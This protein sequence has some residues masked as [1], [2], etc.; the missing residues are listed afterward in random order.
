VASRGSQSVGAPRKGPE[1]LDLRGAATGVGSLPFRS[2]ERAVRWSLTRYRDVPFWPQ[3]PRRSSAES[4]LRQFHEPLAGANAA[5][6]GPFLRAMRGRFALAVKGQV[7]GPVTLWLA[8]GGTTTLAAARRESERAAR[9]VTRALAALGP[10]PIVFVDEPALHELRTR[11]AR[12]VARADAAI[13]AVI[14]TIRRRGARAGIHTCGPPPI[15]RLLRARPDFLGLDFVRYRDRLLAAVAR[16]DVRAFVQRGGAF[17]FGIVPTAVP[18]GFAADRVARFLVHDLLAAFG[19]RRIVI[20]LL[21]RSLVTA[22]CGTG[23]RSVDD[24]R[25]VARALRSIH[26]SLRRWLRRQET[27]ARGQ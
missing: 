25:A 12:D 6:F 1:F 20:D 27:P 3:L 11:P 16:R 9:D 17:A 18:A 5:A 24:E 2:P 13:R 15:A 26:A 4:M 10:P 19:D 14:E 7:T 21:G 8:S 23:L 22:A